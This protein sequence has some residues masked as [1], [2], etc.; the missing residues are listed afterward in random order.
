MALRTTDLTSL[1]VLD[2]T[3]P[4]TAISVSSDANSSLMVVVYDEI[5]LTVYDYLEKEV[6]RKFKVTTT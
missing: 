3:A 4:I 2:R 6:V 5:R 1:K